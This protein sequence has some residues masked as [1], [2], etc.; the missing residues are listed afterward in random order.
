M[1]YNSA[2]MG[3]DPTKSVHAAILARVAGGGEK[4]WTPSDFADLGNRN[5]VDKALQ[6]MVD[7]GRVRRIARGLYDLPGT[8]ELTGKVT[9]PYYMSV[10]EAVARRDRARWLADGMTAANLV[11][12]T[13]AVPAK[14]EV[15]V[16]TRL[17]PIVI[18]NQRIEFRQASPRRLYWA[19]HPAMH[20]VQALHWLHD[21]L[22][23]EAERARVDRS[24]RRILANKEHGPGIAADLRAGLGA[25]PIW[26][27]DVLRGPLAD[28]GEA[29]A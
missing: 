10:I 23:S 4:V 11:G 20:L 7:K 1:V 9:V 29:P 16:D 14:I 13:N 27:Q 25:L 2:I 21:V 28:S 12:L 24:I 17:R 26:M 5:A 3:S 6:R 22:G 18:G 8:C 15:L 19:G